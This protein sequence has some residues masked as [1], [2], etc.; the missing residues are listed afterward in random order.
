METGKVSSNG[1]E[2]GNNSALV[3]ELALRLLTYPADQRTRNPQLLPGQ[4][5][6][7]LPVETPLPPDSRV[8]GSLIRG[9]YFTEIV[10]DTALSPEQVIT[11]YV[12]KL[13]ANGWNKPD[14]FPGH[15]GG[16]APTIP[17]RNNLFCK[18][19]HGPSLSIQAFI[20]PA[21][22]KI[23]NFR[24]NL[25]TNSRNSP[26]AQLAKQRAYS[27]KGPIPNLTT[28][29]ESRQ[30]SRGGGGG[31]GRWYSEA[32]LETDLNLTTIAAHYATQLDKAGWKR[33]D[34][35]QNGP[36]AWQRWTFVDEQNE[37]WKGLF[38]I[39][40]EAAN[41]RQHLLYIKADLADLGLRFF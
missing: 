9:P 22:E 7:N 28:P 6:P 29:P 2:P 24:L 31:S 3:Q 8:V 12:E 14:T 4:L 23:T 16:F 38:F 25:D 36:V 41:P 19:P 30:E 17:G 13:T 37:E 32:Y 18:G 26:C 15:M 21:D 11:F 35:G 34:E 5:P 40:K 20:S 39:V 1:P 33:L 27:E 10:A